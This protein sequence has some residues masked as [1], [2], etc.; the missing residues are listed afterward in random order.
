MLKEVAAEDLQIG[1]FIHDLGVSWWQHSFIRPRFKLESQSTLDA[2]R[3]CT[4]KVVI[5][6]DKGSDV[7]SFQ[8]TSNVEVVV[9]AMQS[10]PKVT[11]DEELPVARKL[12]SEARATVRQAMLDARTGAMSGLPQIREL[13]QTMMESFDRH[14]GALLSLIG[15]KTKDDYTFSHCVAVGTLMVALG[16]QLGLD[17][18]QL[19]EAGTAGLL[20]DVGKTLVPDALLNKPARL[21][22]AEFEIVREHPQLGYRMLIDAGFEDS[23]AL[24]VVLHHHER[25]DGRGYPD[26]LSGEHVTQLARMGAVADVYDAVTSDRCYHR[27]VQPANVLKMLLSESGAHFDGDIVHAF[28]RT[29]GI[30]PNR[31]LVRLK[32]GRLA[33]VLE[34]NEKDATSPIVK[35]FFST[36]NNGPL[37]PYTLNPAVGGDPIE[38]PEDPVDW[39]LDVNQLAGLEV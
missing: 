13:A 4:P 20:H 35:V 23:R 34:Q 32:S 24:E 33:A 16:K 39:K 1:M 15:L 11:L 14:P 30:Y 7:L 31:S 29:V 27:A 12:I 38:S 9:P 22:A 8:A 19:R 36:K 25:L 3:S 26:K 10:P 2:V 5:D 6:T 17:D 21:S 18:E 37:V 28:I